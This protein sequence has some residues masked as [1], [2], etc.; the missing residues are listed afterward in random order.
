MGEEEPAGALDGVD[1]AQGGCAEGV[2]GDED[3]GGAERAHAPVV[4]GEGAAG[5]G[6]V[7][8]DEDK[9]GAG[10]V[11]DGGDEVGEDVEGAGV[12]GVAAAVAV[13]A[14]GDGLLDGAVATCAE[15]AGAAAAPVT[16]GTAPL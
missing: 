4:E 12:A 7:A 14:E 8:P 9:G 1:L 15:A 11:G 2:E 5:A 13:H 10:G 16:A 3:G 6:M